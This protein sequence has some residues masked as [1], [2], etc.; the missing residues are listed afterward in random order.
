M[1]YQC[2]EYNLY[3]WMI[4]RKWNRGLYEAFKQMYNLPSLEVLHRSSCARLGQGDTIIISPYSFNP[5]HP[6]SYPF[7]EELITL[8]RAK[9][10]SVKLFQ[11]GR[12]NE[13]LLT[14]VDDHFMELPLRS[15]EELIKGCRMWVSVDNFL[16]HLVNSMME[17]VRGVV[18]WGV[19]NPE[20]FGYDYN[21]N[22]LRSK[23]YLRP[24]QF[25]VWPGFKKKVDSF[26]RPEKVVERIEETYGR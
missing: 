17:Q 3:M 1:K 12:R 18:L 21:L 10:P 7:W 2:S 8:L 9:Y 22:I 13:T 16:Q 11:I 19:S 25:G 5:D 26:E 23:S 6:K 24:D 14:G 4:D 15:V 20:L